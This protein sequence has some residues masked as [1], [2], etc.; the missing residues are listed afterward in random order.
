MIT[1]CDIFA[2]AG[3]S[4]SGAASVPG[5]HVAIAANHPQYRV[6]SD[7]TVYG[8]R[9]FALRGHTLPDG[10]MRVTVAGRHILRH[11]LVAE[12]F[13]G[14][15]PDGMQV[16]H[17]DGDKSN[18]RVDNLEYV[19]PAENTR[20]SISVLGTER[21]PGEKNANARLTAR[22]VREMRRLHASGIP[23]TRVGEQFGIGPSHAWRIATRKSWRHVK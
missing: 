12:T 11:V 7:G 18:N 8:P 17:L 4:S 23:A 6:A 22:D 20:H 19:T 3:G 16:N 21:A 9:G 10:Y 14:P 1:L 5:V 15:K 13:M 2:G